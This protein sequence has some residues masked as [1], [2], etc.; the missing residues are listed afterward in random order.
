LLLNFK[1]E[2]GAICSGIQRRMKMIKLLRKIAWFVWVFS[3]RE[4]SHVV[5]KKALCVS[6][7]WPHEKNT[8]VYL[9]LRRL[10]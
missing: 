7:L 5:L 10:L 2:N 4:K 9:W 6:D 1:Q 8:K 3:S